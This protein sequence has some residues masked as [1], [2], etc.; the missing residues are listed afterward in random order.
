MHKRIPTRWI[1]LL[2]FLSLTTTWIACSKEQS[3]EKSNAQVADNGNDDD[4]NNGGGNEDSTSDNDGDDDTTDTGDSDSTG[5][6]DV[7]FSAHG[8]GD[9]FGGDLGISYVPSPENMFG[10]S[11]R[12][13][14]SVGVDGDLDMT[15]LTLTGQGLLSGN[16]YHGPIES[17][18]I[19]PAEVP[20][21]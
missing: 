7:D 8:D 6:S 2:F 4:N 10:L 5:V 19:V 12:T 1:A 3:F 21:P 17:K 18:V 15:A 13:G 20:I 9:D 11:Y 16:S 14:A